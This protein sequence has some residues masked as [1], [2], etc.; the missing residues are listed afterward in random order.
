MPLKG[1]KTAEIIAREKGV[2]AGLPAVTMV[3]KEAGCISQV[4][5][6]RHDGDTVKAGTRL[7]RIT[8]PVAGILTAERT[9]LNLLSLMSG[10][11]TLTRAYVDR[12]KGTGAKIYDTRKTP[13]GLRYAA[14]YAVLAG[15]GQ[16]HRM[17]LYDMVLIK[18]NHLAAMP[19]S[20]AVAL[21]KKRFPALPVE[22]ETEN[23]CQFREAL[24]TRADI[25][26]LD[27]MSPSDMRKA[28]KL[29]KNAGHKAALEASGGIKLG[30]I[31]AIAK[32]GVD[33]IAVGAITHSYR[34]LDIAMEII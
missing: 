5:F 26:M 14:K 33:R 20:H 16:N 13:P 10:I 17:G 31:R 19:L 24:T 9:I 2:I 27:N 29:K 32:T 8:G 15:G 28:A 30:N 18:D 12:V 3:L 25:I 23:L 11:A 34:I 1:V 22:I 21:A 4:R 7:A 6:L